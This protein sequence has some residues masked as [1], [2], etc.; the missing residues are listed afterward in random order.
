M[1]KKVN[2]GYVIYFTWGFFKG[3]ISSKKVKLFKVNSSSEKQKK[4]KN[5]VNSLNSFI[6]SGEMKFTKQSIE[7]CI[8]CTARVFCN[9]INGD[10]DKVTFPYKIDNSSI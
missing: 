1:K 2:F 10:I 3:K 8:G 9:H 7:K 5:T 4:L 6:K